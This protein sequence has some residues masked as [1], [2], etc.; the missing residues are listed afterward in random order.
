M[1]TLVFFSI[2]SCVFLTAT[3][4]QWSLYSLHRHHLG[5]PHR[6]SHEARSRRNRVLGQVLV[7]AA[8]NVEIQHSAQIQICR[9]PRFGWGC[10][11]GNKFGFSWLGNFDEKEFNQLIKEKEMLI[12]W[13]WL[14]R[15]KI[16]DKLFFYG[17]CVYFNNLRI[18]DVETYV[19]WGISW[20]WLYMCNYLV[21]YR[22]LVKKVILVCY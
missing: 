11:W 17:K 19:I 9:L 10:C 18:W 2:I 15:E 20:F 8:A 13:Y 6:H 5:P 12:S 1:N 7:E 21:V 4:E 16:P 3:H 22:F 14:K